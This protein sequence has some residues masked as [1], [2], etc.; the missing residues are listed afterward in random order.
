MTR[1][2][3]VLAVFLGLL[4]GCQQRKDDASASM[5]QAAAQSS[6]AV[7]R[8]AP[9]FTL[10][11]Q[12]DR[13]V[14]LSRLRGKWVVLYFYPKDDTPGCAC[15]ANEFTLLLT[16]FQDMN[17]D[18]LGVSPDDPASHRRFIE[19]YSLKLTLLS[20]PQRQVMRQYGAWAQTP[21]A[22]ADSGHVV[23]STYIIDPQGVIRR[24]W[25]EVIPQGHAERVRQALAQLQAGPGPR[26]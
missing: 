15:Q 3:A 21:L 19:K 14:Q 24:H 7:G 5:E 10:P 11:D 8:P 16:E 22:G 26:S 23:R 6:T 9:D 25:P 20:D 18:I 1:A 13:P 17:A 2:I 4:Q 12:Q